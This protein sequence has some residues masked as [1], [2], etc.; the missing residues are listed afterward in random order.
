MAA[1]YFMGA[2]D[3]TGKKSGKWYGM[4]SLLTRNGFGNWCI[5]DVFCASCGVYDSVIKD[6]SVGD[7]VEV[8]TN[9]H[10]Q[11]VE[12]VAH[13]SFPALDLYDD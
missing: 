13:D 1:C 4:V 2:R 8:T 3:G 10:G 11:L 6:C 12:C 7:P 9:L 5:M